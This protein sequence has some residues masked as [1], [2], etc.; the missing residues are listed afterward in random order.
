LRGSDDIAGNTNNKQVPQ[1]LIKHDLRRNA[2][3]RA[4]EDDREGLLSR[5]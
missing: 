5:R 2:R 3:I 1:A 4:P